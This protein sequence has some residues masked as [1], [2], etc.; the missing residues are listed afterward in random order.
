[1]NSF[2]MQGKV[3][4]NLKVAKKFSF[5]NKNPNLKKKKLYFANMHFRSTLKT[6]YTVAI[7]LQVEFLNPNEHAYST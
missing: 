3:F 7:S 2:L 1:M 6:F 5:Q 4:R